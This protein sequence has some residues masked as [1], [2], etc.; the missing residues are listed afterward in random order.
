LG[1]SEKNKAGVNPKRLVIRGKIYCNVKTIT[2]IMSI[3]LIKGEI[4]PGPILRPLL[5]KP[6][7][8]LL[9]LIT[10]QLSAILKVLTGNYCGIK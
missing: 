2:F 4:P 9:K 1:K 3:H 5:G 10:L 6:R 7:L 8:Y